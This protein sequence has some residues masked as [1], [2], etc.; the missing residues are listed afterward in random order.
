[1]KPRAQFKDLPKDFW[2]N[3]RTISE[4]VGYTNRNTKAIKIPSTKEVSVKM[5]ELGLGTDHLFSGP[6]RF[7]PTGELLFAYFEYRAQSLNEYV[8]PRLMRVERAREV[9]EQLRRELAPTWP[10]PM[11]KQSGDMKAPAYFTGIIN[12]LLEANLD[13]SPCDYDPRALT[14]VTTDHRPL[15]TLARRVDGAFPS[16]RNPLAVWEIKEYYYTTT[17]G[18]RISDGVYE[19]LL[20]GLELEELRITEGIHVGHY[21]M[22]D[23]YQTWWEMGRS[24]VCRIFDML[25]MG[26]IDEAL[27]GYEVVERLPHIAREWVQALRG[28]S[29]P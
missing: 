23:A 12:M 10:V 11:N 3:V 27:F 1:M 22:V 18:S 19:T 4:K 9:Y 17:F 5:A 16:T 21:F 2:A 24:Y 13:G 15:R 20:D 25:H 26:Y 29:P 14:T 7:T 8:R 28:A 6:S